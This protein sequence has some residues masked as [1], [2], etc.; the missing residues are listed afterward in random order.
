MKITEI[1][2]REKKKAKQKWAIMQ[3]M[4][5]AL[6]TKAFHQ[7]KIEDICQDLSI[8]KVTFFN[9]FESKEQVLSYFVS[10]WEYVTYDEI[11]HNQLK[12]LDALTHIFKSI[13]TR[14]EGLNIMLAVS[15]FLIK[16]EK[17]IANTIRP[18]ELY[19]FSKEAFEHNKEYINLLEFTLRIIKDFDLSQNCSKKLLRQIIVGFYGVPLW[20]KTESIDSLE[21]GY[22]GLLEDIAAN[23]Y[24][25]KATNK[26]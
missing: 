4:V 1:G 17:M 7:I 20:I 26:I 5:E 21:E 13:S 11:C 24:Y 22:E 16:S 9:Y 15:Q 10:Y 14:K 12:G 18:Y 2:L 25:F 3:A 6:K 8:S 23:I 19:L